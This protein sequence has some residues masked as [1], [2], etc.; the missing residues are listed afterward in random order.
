[1]GY[2]NQPHIFK[3]MTRDT[4]LFIKEKLT[5][6]ETL[7]TEKKENKGEEKE[8]LFIGGEFI[9]KG[10]KVK[11]FFKIM[12]EIRN[13]Y[14][15]LIDRQDLRFILPKFYSF[16]NKAYPKLRVS[17]K[18]Y[19]NSFRYLEK[20]IPRMYAYIVNPEETKILLVKNYDPLEGLE[21][22]QSSGWS[23]PGGKIEGGESQE[24]CLR[25]EIKEE[26]DIDEENY[27]IKELGEVKFQEKEAKIFKVILDSNV[28]FKAQPFEI[29][30]AEW[31]YFDELP[32][33][34]NMASK[35]LSLT[36]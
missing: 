17:F 31:F 35:A 24:E 28:N 1:M 2:Q 13:A 26:L 7:I 3:E 18:S 22:Y 21:N 4:Y 20:R 23:L 34:V 25:R 29:E 8:I 15:E 33:L 36:F 16:C 30:K 14:W 9:I 10:E 11:V 12:H 6:V 19:Y 27:K 32:K 5:E